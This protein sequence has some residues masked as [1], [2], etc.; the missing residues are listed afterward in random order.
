M[1]AGNKKTVVPGC[2]AK[3][4]LKQSGESKARKIVGRG[5]ENNCKVSQSWDLKEASQEVEWGWHKRNW[6]GHRP[7]K[8]K[9][10]KPVWQLYSQGVSAHFSHPCRDRTADVV[11]HREAELHQLFR[12]GIVSTSHRAGRLHRIQCNHVLRTSTADT[13]DKA[14][15]FFKIH[16]HLVKLQK[17]HL[18]RH[19]F[20]SLPQLSFTFIQFIQLCS[21]C[22]NPILTAPKGCCFCQDP[23]CM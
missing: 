20:Y 4:Y 10:G 7:G 16:L 15:F 2:S 18:G 9:K 1:E 5:A 14:T 6:T 17:L 12:A 22:Q 13:S 21:H 8:K 11:R 23:C 19:S 3:C